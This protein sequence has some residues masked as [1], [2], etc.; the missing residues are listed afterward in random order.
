MTALDL[1]QPGIIF[2]GIVLLSQGESLLKQPEI[3][4][5]RS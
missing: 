2:R 4:F 5:E 3:Y 1:K